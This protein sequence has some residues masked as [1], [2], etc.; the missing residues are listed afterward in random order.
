MTYIVTNGWPE[1]LV[2]L[3][4]ALFNAE[5]GAEDED[6]ARAQF[7]LD[8]RV[9]V[10]KPF[11]T[12]NAR[13]LFLIRRL[14]TGEHSALKS[15]RMKPIDAG[16]WRNCEGA[17]MRVVG[18]LKRRINGE[19]VAEEMALAANEAW[20]ADYAA[21]WP[22]C[23]AARTAAYAADTL[24]ADSAAYDAVYAADTAASASDG[25]RAVACAVRAAAMAAA[26]ADLIASIIEAR[27]DE[28]QSTVTGE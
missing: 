14:E 4:T 16:W 9:A 11:D 24:Y 20:R 25:G 6:K 1:W 27:I 28:T 8:M 2:E 17:A 7:A 26:R 21:P 13:D 19:N 23:Y 12:D 22:A 10:S 3:N 15:M 18:L 5:V